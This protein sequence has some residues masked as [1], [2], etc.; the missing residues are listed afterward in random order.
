MVGNILNT[1]GNT[2]IISIPNSNLS[3]EG[4]ILFKY[5]RNNL[6]GS[7]KDGAA[8]YLIE[9]AEKRGLLKPSGTIIKSSSGACALVALKVAQLLSQEDTVVCMI[10]DGA[11]RYISTLFNDEWMIEQDFSIDTTIEDIRKMALE[12]NMWCA[13]PS[14]YADYM[15]NLYQSLEVPKS[16]KQ[17]NAEILK[18]REHRKNK[19]ISKDGVTLSDCE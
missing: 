16:T 14:K 9:E 11:E 19:L 13:N 8:T 17:I 4:Q 2:P 15:P 6:G 3:D 5:E 12:I 10:S 18:K 1:I 7:I